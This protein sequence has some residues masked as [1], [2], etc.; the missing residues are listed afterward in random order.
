MLVGI[1]ILESNQNYQIPSHVLYY[2]V[3]LYYTDAKDKAGIVP[4]LYYINHHLLKTQIIEKN[5][6]Y[7]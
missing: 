6:Y 2:P 3:V 7:K 1:T 5:R 4:E